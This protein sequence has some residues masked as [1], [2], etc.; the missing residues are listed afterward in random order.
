LIPNPP[1]PSRLPVGALAVVLVLVVAAAAA[2]VGM[3]WA[4]NPAP[5]GPFAKCKTAAQIAPHVYKAPPPMCIDVNKPYNAAILTTKGELKVSFL[6]RSAPV[7][8]NN[9]IVLAV[10]GYFTGQRFFKVADWYV[11][12][13]D[14]TNT[15]QGGPDYMLPE[16][17]APA[18]T[19][20]QGSIGMARFPYGISGSQFF[21]IKQPWPGGN[22]TTVY[23]HFATVILDASSV[24]SQL[25]TD[26]RILR[27]DVTRG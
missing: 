9:F 11:Q 22:P 21:V 27:I 14:P 24:V 1:A 23:N 2:G 13:G 3:A 5:S 26:D 7:T 17:P 25:T 16:E 10:N 6:V 20:P 15:G 4:A 8:A 19:W 18:D 12:S